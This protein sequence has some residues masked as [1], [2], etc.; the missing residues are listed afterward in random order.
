MFLLFRDSSNPLAL[1]SQIAKRYAKSFLIIDLVATFPFDLIIPSETNDTGV[2]RSAKLA[3][4][5]KGMKV[6][7]ECAR[8]EA[9][10][11]R[12]T[13]NRKSPSRY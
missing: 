8:S 11:Q 3:N 13:A 4:L 7:R 9:T 12:S 6:R 5:G 10:K 1:S 2:N